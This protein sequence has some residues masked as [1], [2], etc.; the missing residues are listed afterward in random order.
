MEGDEK[1]KSCLNAI[2]IDFSKYLSSKEPR[3]TSQRKLEDE[4]FSSGAI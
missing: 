3:V 4:F 1:E 2:Y